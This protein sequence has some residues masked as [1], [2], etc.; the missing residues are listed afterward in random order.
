MLSVIDLIFVPDPAGEDGVVEESPDG[1]CGEHPGLRDEL[2]LSV[3][4]PL[5][6]PCAEPLVIELVR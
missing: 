3:R 4:Q 1:G 5:G 6:V 2:S